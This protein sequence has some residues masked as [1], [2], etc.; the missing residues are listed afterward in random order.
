MVEG[1]ASSAS[2]QMTENHEEL[3]PHQRVVLPSR[4]T[5]ASWRNGPTGTPR[6]ST[7][8]NARCCTWAGTTRCYQKIGIG[9]LGCIRRNEEKEE[10]DEEH[11]KL[12][13]SRLPKPRCPR[14]QA[15]ERCPAGGPRAVAER[16]RQPRRSTQGSLPGYLPSNHACCIPCLSPGLA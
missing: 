4:G 9:V 2:S 14:S 6:S 7:R 8:G 10:H 12:G 15:G 5:S 3:L 13:D 16:S 11:F 1:N